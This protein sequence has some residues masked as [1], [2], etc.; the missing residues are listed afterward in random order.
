MRMIRFVPALAAFVLSSSHL[1]SQ[2]IHHSPKSTAASQCVWVGNVEATKVS[3]GQQQTLVGTVR[4]VFEGSYDT[5]DQYT[6]VGC[7]LTWTASGTING[8]T[9]TG[10]PFYFNVSSIS[11]YDAILQ[12]QT[13]DQYYGMVSLGLA[14]DSAMFVTLHCSGGT[15][16]IPPDFG[17]IVIGVVDSTFITNDRMTGS[18]T[19]SSAPGYRIFY[20]WN[21]H[22]ESA[23]GTKLSI[24]SARY[25]NWLPR[26][27]RNEIEGI[28]KDVGDT[29]RFRA[30]LVDADGNTGCAKADSFTFELTDVSREPGVSMNYP[31][32]SEAEGDYDLHFKQE[33]NSPTDIMSSERL[34]L[35]TKGGRE[36]TATVAS[37]DWGAWGTLKVTAYMQGGTTLIGFL[38]GYP[39]ITN[40]PIP[41]RS[42]G[43]LIAD[44]WK[45]DHG[46][47]GLA[48][49]DDAENKPDG[50][51]HPGDGFTLYEEYRGFMEG[52]EHIDGDPKK[53][54]LFVFSPD[55][56]YYPGVQLFKGV[57]RL[58][59]H[60][61]LWGSE[62]DRKVR[63]MNF[64]HLQG[65]HQSFDQH[66]LW[67]KTVSGLGYSFSSDLGPPKKVDS[68]NISTEATGFRTIRRGARKEIT[69]LLNYT[70]AHELGHAVHI[71]HHGEADLKGMQWRTVV[72][73]N[74]VTGKF[75]FEFSEDA[76]QGP[77][78]PKQE[79][80]RPFTEILND[81]VYIAVWGGEH[82]G[83]EDCIMRYNCAYAYI[84]PPGTTSDIRYI[85]M[86][87]E[88]TGLFLCDKKE[89]DPGGVNDVNR[90]PR[91][92]YGSAVL[93]NCR[94]QI[95][96]N[97]K[98][99]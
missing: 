72:P 26:A 12:I 64:N 90:Q 5:I 40:I 52:G 79:N 71:D 82:C 76:H 43:S 17:E 31:K 16:K 94:G 67:I 78:Y 36:A 49:D 2:T 97:D 91:S 21:L 85:V 74:L 46:V 28:G 60:Y 84:P 32:A 1:P 9:Y 98:F 8:C 73:L 57:T 89:D 3:P 63:V 6:L 95:C 86:G 56:E 92:R 77:I 68:V 48:D 80:G 50:D 33:L 45:I 24:E 14:T 15:M 58:N 22:K 55:H 88:R 51:G 83:V 37:F 61:Q 65:P 81:Y 13:N 42:S 87:T 62:F 23:G 93:G 35:V 44:K 75:E 39:E 66:G 4:F 7:D 34:T 29:L 18:S 20:G 54:D 69:N 11:P 96:V 25:E 53:K 19:F 30:E 47:A 27:S 59:V 41:R 10:G 70:V 99:H 38:K